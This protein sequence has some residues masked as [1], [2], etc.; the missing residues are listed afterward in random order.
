MEMRYKKIL[1]V[2]PDYTSTNFTMPVAPIGLGYIAEFLKQSGIDYFIV[3]MRLGYKFKDLKKVIIDTQPD[4]IGISLMSFMYKDHYKFIQSIKKEFPDIRIV[5]GGPHVSTCKKKVL[6]DCS[7]IDFGIMQEGELPLL[8]LC[9]G[10]PVTDIASLLYRDNGNITMNPPLFDQE[11]ELDRLPFPRY[12]KFQLHKYGYGISLVSSR[13]CPYSCIYCTASLTRRKFRARSAR[14][15]VDEIEY[16][17]NRGYREFD[18]QE[19]NPTF[20]KK[21]M[22]EFCDEIEKRKLN[23]LVIMCGNGVRADKVD[24]EILQRMRDVGF[25]RLGFGVE[26]GNNKVLKS[27]KKGETIEVIKKA[28]QEACDLGFFVSLFF[29]VGSPTE[30]AQD[31][32]DSMD[33][34]L[35]YPIS[36][37]NFFNLIPLPQTELFNWVEENNYFL[38]KPE[39]YLNIGSSIQMKCKPVFETPYFIRKERIKALKK[40]KSIERFVKRRTIAKTLN[41]IYPANYVIAWLYML[42]IVQNIENQLL[43]FLI[44]RKL[45]DKVR[46]RV[47]LLFYK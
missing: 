7:A 42:P 9:Q 25:K 43:R 16:W 19:D 10:R 28:I 34:A 24:R 5:A 31:V 21:R 35:S 30:T 11:L 46:N 27:I 4:L 6:E 17:H 45:V 37:V 44:Y 23:D 14:N 2:Y 8:L 29:I 40:G 18:L 33:I 47:R 32:Q 36:H 22:F 39:V 38:L 1:F 41:N 12:E 20:D 13:G 3:D 15:V 26:A